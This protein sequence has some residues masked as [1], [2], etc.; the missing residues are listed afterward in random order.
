MQKADSNSSARTNADS[1]QKVEDMFGSSNNT[2]PNV[3]GLPSLSDDEK[4]F[5]KMEAKFYKFTG[6]L[7]AAKTYEELQALLCE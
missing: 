3:V 5:L 7:I 6:A 2:K 4:E 1:E